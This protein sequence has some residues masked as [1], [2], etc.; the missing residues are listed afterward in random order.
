MS[1]TKFFPNNFDLLEYE[2]ISNEKRDEVINTVIEKINSKDLR[3]SGENNNDVWEK[4]WGEI[5]NQISK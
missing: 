1:L 5:L 2:I 3:V 4:G